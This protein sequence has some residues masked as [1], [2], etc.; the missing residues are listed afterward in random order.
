MQINDLLR[1]AEV[2]TGLSS[3]AVFSSY[4]VNWKIGGFCRLDREEPTNHV[5]FHNCWE[6]HVVLTGS[7]FLKDETGIHPVT[8]GSLMV[9]APGIQHE[10]LVQ[11]KQSLSLLW[12]MFDIQ[13]EETTGGK[14]E[15][16][17][18]IITRFLESHQAVNR[19]STEVL[20]YLSFMGE[21]TD[22][23]GK[24]DNWLLRMI[25]EM[26][27]FFLEKLSYSPALNQKPEK[28]PEEVFRKIQNLISSDIGRKYSVPELAE[29]CGMS[30]RSLQYLF[31]KTLKIT[32]TEYT[33]EIKANHAARALLRGVRVQHAG[34]LIGIPDPAQF[35]RFF[36][37]FFGTPPV[38]YRQR[39]LENLDFFSTTFEET[40]FRKF[41]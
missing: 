20:S 25:Q 21:Y 17:S 30:P 16:E 27:L 40:G 14:K 22:R 26:L 6:G 23:T 28:R 29:A 7:G 9:T 31:R 11:D 18:R 2:L 38:K 36:K 19:N 3:Q 33:A 4:I 39:S 1:I 34:E 35:S 41:V 15:P 12:F 5:H 8:P 37:R 32:L 10:L 13:P 24:P